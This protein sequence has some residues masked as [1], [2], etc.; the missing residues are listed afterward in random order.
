MIVTGCDVGTSTT[1][2]VV[3]KDDEI[4][5]DIATTATAK[6]DQTVK[7]VIE[8]SLSKAHLA[9]ND[10]EYCISTGWGRKTVSYANTNMS[11]IACHGKGA[12]WLIPSVRTVVDGGSEGT[13]VISVDEKGKIIE[14]IT[15]PKCSA[16]AGKFLEVMAEVLELNLEDLGPLAQ[17]SKNRAAITSQCSV[18]A[19]SEVIAHINEGKDLAD[20]VDGINY[21]IAGRLASLVKGISIKEDV[22]ITGGVAKN[23]SVVKYLGEMLGVDIKM[24]PADPQIVGAIGATLFA[25]E[26][27]AGK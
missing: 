5:F 26:K 16:G 22:T 19:E 21:S 27:M 4:F 15:N 6:L 3:M 25:R 7:K 18:F 2:A 1:K 20:V 11:E 13:R 14:Y 23:I 10:I 9:W 17:Q 12:Q 8:G 24:V